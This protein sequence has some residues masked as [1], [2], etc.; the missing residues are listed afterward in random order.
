LMSVFRQ[1]CCV[2]DDNHLVVVAVLL[3]RQGSVSNHLLPVADCC[4]A[5]CL[6]FMY[7]VDEVS[8]TWTLSLVVR[9]QDD[10]TAI[11]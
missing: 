2:I 7:F 8:R 5:S 9:G 1:D 4:R 11:L 6:A 10:G 3:L